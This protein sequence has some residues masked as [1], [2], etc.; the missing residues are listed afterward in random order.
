MSWT[1]IF[2]LV[3]MFWGG[4]M[5]NRVFL[6]PALILLTLLNVQIWAQDQKAPEIFFEETTFNCGEVKEG[7][8]IEHT[9]VVY[10]KG[11]AVLNIQNVKPG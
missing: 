8:L 5:K 1:A 2:N 6:F 3:F 7:T 9:Y 11:D 4:W 10:N